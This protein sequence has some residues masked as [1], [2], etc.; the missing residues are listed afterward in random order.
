[1]DWVL[2]D[3]SM[4]LFVHF[5][6]LEENMQINL[7]EWF[8]DCGVHYLLCSQVCHFPLWTKSVL[9]SIVSHSGML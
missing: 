7:E 4:S 6:N 2:T 5:L 1:M 8:Q 3:G 9:G